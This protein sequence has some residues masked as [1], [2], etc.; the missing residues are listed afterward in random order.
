MFGFSRGAF[1][2]RALIEMVRCEGLVPRELGGKVTSHA[3][4]DR[5]SIAAWRAYRQKSVSWK[6]LLPIIVRALRN[7]ILFPFTWFHR[8]YDAP[9]WMSKDAAAK[10]DTVVKATRLQERNGERIEIK[11]V[12]LFDTV[13][14]FG[15]PLEE[16]RSAIDTLI[17]PISFPIEEMSQKV[18]RV[19]HAL[20]LDDERT[21]FHPIRSNGLKLGG[22]P[23]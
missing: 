7:L 9:F 14:A 5:D 20:S 10:L 3:E 17:W 12:G 23:R 13:E 1:T 19:R 4:M 21:T 11:F 22:N 2:I 15:V 8:R 16:L 18:W 6:S